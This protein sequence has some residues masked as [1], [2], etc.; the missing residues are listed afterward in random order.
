MGPK[1][2]SGKQGNKA[3]ATPEDAADASRDNS[4]DGTGY[5]SSAEVVR[6]NPDDPDPGQASTSDDP[7][8][9]SVTAVTEDPGQVADTVARSQVAS[10]RAD[11]KDMKA[12]N[13]NIRADVKAQGAK[14]DNFTALMETLS[15]RPFKIGQKQLP[16]PYMVSLLFPA[17]DAPNDFGKIVFDPSRTT[18]SKVS[19]LPQLSHFDDPDL[20]Q[21]LERAQQALHNSSVPTSY[22]GNYLA[23]KM[24]G[25][26]DD[27]GRTFKPYTDWHLCALA[28]ISC[29]K[30]YRQYVVD[31]NAAIIAIASDPS[32]SLENLKKLS[33][34]YEFAPLVGSTPRERVDNFIG[35]VTTWGFQLPPAIKSISGELWRPYDS[36]DYA[37]LIRNAHEQILSF[38]TERDK[39][40]SAYGR[41]QHLPSAEP[42]LLSLL[43]PASPSSDHQ[44]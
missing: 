37:S 7:G 2:K 10:L 20:P 14:L 35:N 9:L 29:N 11:M 41:L 32:L 12:Q 26:Y 33:L 43:G 38:I 28:I 17:L 31:R 6:D 8:Q 30:G 24:T 5:E 3:K 18:A 25:S 27:V 19:N 34:A 22:W 16:S 13:A 1:P 42:L 23:T 40:L 39:D 44:A 4:H 36:A 21:K 15:Q